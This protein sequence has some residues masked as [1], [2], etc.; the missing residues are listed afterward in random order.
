MELSTIL[1]ILGI[2]IVPA[3]GYLLNK[4][5]SAQEEDIKDLKKTAELLFK[6]HDEDA[7]NLASL[8]LQIAKEHYLKHEL[9]ARFTSLEDAF[10]D[11]MQELGRK[12][13]KLTDILVDHVTKEDGRR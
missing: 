5:D 13:D 12:F 4:K 11:G 2:L 8:Q 6:K 1:S 10:R 3:I 7:A 9:D